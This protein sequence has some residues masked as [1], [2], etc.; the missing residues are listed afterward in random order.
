[1]QVP[2]RAVAH[3]EV[4]DADMVCPNKVEATRAA[5]TRNFPARCI[6][7]RMKA[8]G[9]GFGGIATKTVRLRWFS[10]R[11]GCVCECVLEEEFCGMVEGMC[12]FK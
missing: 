4:G 5:R 3:S 10:P 6:A 8:I 12:N 11:S 2:H 9:A 7:G 1:M